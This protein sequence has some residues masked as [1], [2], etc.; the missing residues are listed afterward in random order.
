MR[1]DVALLSVV[2]ALLLVLFVM[3]PSETMDNSRHH[4]NDDVDPSELNDRKEA[5]LP[6]DLD[7]QRVREGEPRL[8]WRY[9]YIACNLFNN[10]HVLPHFTD[11]LRVFLQRELFPKLLRELE[12]DRLEEAGQG[13]A[14]GDQKQQ[15]GPLDVAY[16]VFFSVFE[17]GSTDRTNQLISELLVPM[18]ESLGIHHGKM[19][20]RLSGRVCGGH[21]RR[22]ARMDRIQWMA[23]VR[24]AAM[25]PL[26]ANGMRLFHPSS[27]NVL[28]T[29]PIDAGNVSKGRSSVLNTSDDGSMSLN[30]DELVVLFFN[31][32]FFKP[33][34][35]LRLLMTNE[36]SEASSIGQQAEEA[37]EEDHLYGEV[38]GGRFDMACGM[39]YYYS[40]YDRWVTR[41]IDGMAFSSYPPYAS[42]YTSQMMF[43]RAS[44]MSASFIEQTEAA[45]D[46]AL[47]LQSSSSGAHKM[48]PEKLRAGGGFLSEKTLTGI[49]VRCC[50]NGLAA[51]RGSIFVEAALHKNSGD[52]VVHEE[53]QDGEYRTV[54]RSSESGSAA[55]PPMHPNPAGGIVFRNPATTQWNYSRTQCYDSECLLLCKDILLRRRR[56]ALIANVNNTEDGEAQKPVIFINPFVK[57]AYEKHFFE[58]QHDHG[59]FGSGAFFSLM[60]WMR[61]WTWASPSAGP[62]AGSAA[63]PAF[64][65]CLL[66]ED[67]YTPG[68]ADSLLHPAGLLISGSLFLAMLWFCLRSSPKARLLVRNLRKMRTS[69][70]PRKT[71]STKGE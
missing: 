32:I 31:D 17:N 6:L 37:K 7:G 49:P 52:S 1:P 27:Q 11:A 14:L 13:G 60:R 4:R 71:G 59:F 18:L 35:V 9:F 47:I 28:I 30:S 42:D 51:I 45:G 26:Y 56:K 50:W 20:V 25:Q 62:L 36:L 39:D 44:K 53:A 46:A 19:E 21:S 61:F 43:L 22:P 3:F 55:A 12:W 57:V 29:S 54:M 68:L 41:G 24:N 40:F 15:H 5:R 23:C 58:L 34:D 67:T 70:T 8:R 69:S 65:E 66:L 38:R 2:F 48:I 10:E 64:L 63:D 33:K 16:R